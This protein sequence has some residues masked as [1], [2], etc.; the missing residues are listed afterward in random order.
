MGQI[1]QVYVK[2]SHPSIVNKELWETVQLELEHR[3]L[4]WETHELRTLGRY[5]DVQPFT[6]KVVCGK[7]GAVY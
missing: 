5:T 2:D 3:R 7:C 4:F 1:E 6:C